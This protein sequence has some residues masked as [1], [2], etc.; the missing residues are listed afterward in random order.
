MDTL[1]HNLNSLFDQLG[2]PS[3]DHDIMNFILNNK[4]LAP[5]VKID[6]AE[7]WSPSQAEFI[8]QALVNDS[9]WFEVVGSLD[10]LLR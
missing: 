1:S 4:K 8:R 6:Q 10:T 5:S 2:M 3:T 9:D 7:F